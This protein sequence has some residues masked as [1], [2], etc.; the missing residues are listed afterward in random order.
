M[1]RF[2]LSSWAMS[3]EW[4]EWVWCGERLRQ[5]HPMYFITIYV[6]Q[7]VCVCDSLLMKPS[8]AGKDIGHGYVVTADPLSPICSQIF[9]KVCF[10]EFP[11]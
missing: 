7:R 8:D 5:S 4:V 2:L 1:C 6:D 9:P 11:A 3:M 10:I